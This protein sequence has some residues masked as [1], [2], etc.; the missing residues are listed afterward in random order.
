MN[1]AC[2]RYTQDS[3]WPDFEVLVE[4]LQNEINEAY[5][6][7]YNHGFADA[8]SGEDFHRDSYNEGFNDGYAAYQYGLKKGK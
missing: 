3:D 2:T 8:T 5:E 7:G 4:D 1:M 6:R